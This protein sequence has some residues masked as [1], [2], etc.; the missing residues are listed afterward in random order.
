MI[1]EEKYLVTFGSKCEFD[2]K[3]LLDSPLDIISKCW[4]FTRV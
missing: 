2:G 3:K 1:N 4:N